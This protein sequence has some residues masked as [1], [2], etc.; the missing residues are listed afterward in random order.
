M[1]DLVPGPLA[2]GSRAEQGNILHIMESDERNGANVGK[3]SFGPDSLRV[4]VEVQEKIIS[5]MT[6]DGEWHDEDTLKGLTNCTLIHRQ[7]Y[8]AALNAL[9][10]RVQISGKEQYRLF[11]DTLNKNK[12]LARRVQS[13]SVSDVTPEE[14]TLATTVLHTSPKLS[15]L[16]QLFLAFGTP[17]KDGITL[18]I[19]PSFPAT[20]RQFSSLAH[21][22][23]FHLKIETLDT[24]RK[25]LGSL[26][27][28]ESTILHQVSWKTPAPEAVPQT[29]LHPSSL[30]SHFHHPEN[31]QR[32]S[33]IQG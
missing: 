25:I 17:D 8:P 1:L 24:L 21:V 32:S 5:S 14:R 33:A 6:T 3:S 18:P 27:S 30:Q 9:Y 13:L 2:S 23:F 20:L 12:H 10:D 26:P 29:S 22:Y 15:E 4:P 11:K 28:L 31:Y 19:R 7:L 16:K